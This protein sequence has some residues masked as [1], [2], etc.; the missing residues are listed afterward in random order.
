MFLLWVAS[1]P[2][3][4]SLPLNSRGVGMS[5][6]QLYEQ[7]YS[8]RRSRP[9]CYVGIGQIAPFRCRTAK[10]SYN[11]SDMTISR[12]KTQQHAAA[13]QDLQVCAW[14]KAIKVIWALLGARKNS[15]ALHE[16]RVV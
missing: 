2:Q 13:W 4:Q 10:R 15:R 5:R 11:V 1:P 6:W 16:R 14:R 7:H 8:D 3:A 9:S 12:L